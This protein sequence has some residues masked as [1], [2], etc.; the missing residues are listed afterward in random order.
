TGDALAEHGTLPTVADVLGESEGWERVR[1]SFT[2]AS[3]I[4]VPRGRLA[5]R[6]GD[7]KRARHHFRRALE[8]AVAEG[9][10]VEARGA[11]GELAALC[12]TA[13]D[14][15]IAS[16]CAAGQR[17]KREAEASGALPPAVQPPTEATHARDL[18]SDRELEVLGLV[19]GGR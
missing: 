15:A 17:L 7:A 14:A 19:A 13:D 16:L 12:P 2:T 11:L 10:P 5:L 3:G 8:W 6:L 18:L 4:D 1:F 9:L